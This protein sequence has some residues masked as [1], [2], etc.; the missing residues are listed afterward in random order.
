MPGTCAPCAPQLDIDLSAA[1]TPTAVDFPIVLNDRWCVVDDPLQ[2]ILA[3]RQRA[4]LISGSEYRHR[5][6][7]ASRSGLTRCIRDNCGDLYPGALARIYL[8]PDLHQDW[9]PAANIPAA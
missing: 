6:F 1:A 8:L 5:S 4:N 3:V 7:C 9:T 2:W